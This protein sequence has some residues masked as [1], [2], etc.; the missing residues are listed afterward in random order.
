MG[1]LS[2]NSL[3]QIG[4]IV[5]DIDA[6][7]R[8]FAELFGVPV[9]PTIYGGDYEITKTEFKDEPAPRANC[10]MAFFTLDNG[11]QLELIQPNEA[12]SIWR[13]FLDENGEGMHHIAFR[14]QG[15]Q[16]ITEDCKTFGMIPVQKGEYGSATGRYM[17]LDAKRDLKCLI[18][19][20]EDD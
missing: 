17:Y 8:K 7:K 13:E 10:F 15:I 6:T 4:F 11:F 16:G 2:M 9:P 20:L 5:K 12:P 3:A 19:L 18:E 1:N 14:I